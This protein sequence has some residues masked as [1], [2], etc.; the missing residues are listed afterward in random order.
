MYDIEWSGAAE[1]CAEQL[2]GLQ[3]VREA[4]DITKATYPVKDDAYYMIM[5]LQR[6]D[7]RTGAMIFEDHVE[8]PKGRRLW[9]SKV[10]GI[11]KNGKFI[12]TLYSPGKY[13]QT[14]NKTSSRR[15]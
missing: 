2:V 8:T 1:N 11:E 13:K 12:P 3:Y 5:F 7:P 9:E 14:S 6:D 4:S 10:N 15:A